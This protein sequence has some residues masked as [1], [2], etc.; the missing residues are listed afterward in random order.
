MDSAEFPAAE[1]AFVRAVLDAL[2]DHIYVKDLQGRYLLVNEAGLRERNLAGLADIAG[3]TAY[4]L[5]PRE[6]AERMSAEDR[7]VVESGNPLVNREAK[8]AFGGDPGE[9]ARWHITTKTPMRDALGRVI[10]V[11]GV[12]RDITERRRTE[13]ALRESEQT[14]RAIFDQAAVGITVTSLDS[15]YLRANDR[16]CDLV[17]Y[18]RQELLS[19][20]WREVNPP[21]TLD[22]ALD[23]RRR[24]LADEVEGHDLREK[25]LLRKDGTRIWLALATSL[26]RGADGEPKYFVSVVQDISEARR[27]AAALRESEE[28][29]RQ[30]AHYD[31]LTSLP[32]RALFYDRLKQSLAQAAR[33]RWNVG[34]MLIDL[35]RFK[36]V[37]DTWGHAAGDMLLYQAS[38]RLSGAVR[39]GDTVARLGGDEFAVVLNNLLA[40]QDAGVVAKKMIAR[41]DDPFSIDGKE[42]SA[43]VSIGI[44]VYPG[45]SDEEET[46]LKHADEA[47]YRAKAAG[48]GCH[49]FYRPETNARAAE[50]L[51]T[52]RELRHALERGEFVLH[53]QPKVSV[54][55]GELRGAEALLRWTHPQR[56]LVG[57]AQFTPLLEESGLAAS[58][59]IWV[60]EEV[61]AQV[62]RWRQ[63]G[64]PV[65][66][67]SANLFPRHF[68]R[69]DLGSIISRVLGA[70]RIE[71]DLLEVEITEAPLMA[72]GDEALRA[73][74][75]LKSLGVRCSID[76]FGTGHSSLGHIRRFPIDGLKIDRSF[77][78][79]LPGSRDA[80]AV[81]R[82]VISLA[83]SFGLQVI[84]EGVENE[85]Q[86]A[87]LAAQGC[88]QAQ[89]YRFAR[90]M[91]A[92]EFARA[93]AAGRAT[94]A[95][96]SR[97]S[98]P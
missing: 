24:L 23:Y 11:I 73:L 78:G 55:T 88:D 54:A 45:D 4:E 75:E 65:V 79:E 96:G 53:Y 6:V 89:G 9:Q 81:V 77:V 71:A 62:G 22:D 35:D 72:N 90:P 8:T 67:V 42:L 80:A 82:A 36:Q 76:D 63:D 52:E 47:M 58:V 28:R 92:P 2:P 56:G 50:I 15:R 59:G 13:L 30:L 26:V 34:V 70:C 27:A 3:K 43:S 95:A 93:L 57:P 69:R 51:G 46:L 19:M 25:E 12:N 39:S 7:A 66:P 32:N 29:F 17:G 49:R 83:H 40:P 60:L 87:F 85:A 1:L 10:G 84:A 86:L 48:R 68:I 37:N 44:A 33:N 94:P 64:L 20:G 16:F 97:G 5:V 91:P 18:P 41:F 74:Q 98:R 38:A 21:E 14:F 61:C 31:L